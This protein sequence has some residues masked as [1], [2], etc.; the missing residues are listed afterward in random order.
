MDAWASSI[1]QYHLSR[2][3]QIRSVKTRGRWGVREPDSTLYN[4]TLKKTHEPCHVNYILFV[5]YNEKWHTFSDSS[6]H[7]QTELFHNSYSWNLLPKKEKAEWITAAI[8]LWRMTI[9]CVALTKPLRPSC[10]RGTEFVS[11]WPS[12]WMTIVSVNAPTIMTF[13]FGEQNLSV[14]GHSLAKQTETIC[15][16]FFLCANSVAVENWFFKHR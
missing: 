6:K 5:T 11:G 4:K 1:P 2:S 7:C 14:L 9:A 15:P 13:A 8:L 12:K 16:Y 3:L 10:V